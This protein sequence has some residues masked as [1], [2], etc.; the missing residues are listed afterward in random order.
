MT[1]FFEQEDKEAELLGDPIWD[2]EQEWDLKKKKKSWI[3]TN[4]SLELRTERPHKQ[5]FKSHYGRHAQSWA[6]SNKQFR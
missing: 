6:L 5:N 4:H 1:P 2:R 3:D